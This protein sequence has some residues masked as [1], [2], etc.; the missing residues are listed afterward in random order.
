LSHIVQI[1]TEVRDV[2]AVRAA[3]RRLGKPRPQPSELLF[4]KT[5]VFQ[6]VPRTTGYWDNRGSGR[7]GPPPNGAARLFQAPA[8]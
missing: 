6:D 2:E 1:Q 5:V 8:S 4:Y 3:C 7:G